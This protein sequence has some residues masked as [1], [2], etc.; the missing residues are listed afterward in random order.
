MRLT[1][2]HGF[3]QPL[4]DSVR[5][6]PYDNEGSYITATGLLNPPLQKK[7][8]AIHDDEIEEDVIDNIWSLLGTTG[9][10][11]LENCSTT[12]ISEKRLFTNIAGKKFSGQFDYL[13]LWDGDLT[14]YKF[15]SVWSVV[16]GHEEWGRQLNILHWLLYVNGYWAERLSICAILRDWDKRKAKQDQNYPQA[17]VVM[18]PYPVWSL[19]EQENYIAERLAMHMA[20]DEDIV[21]VCS[22]EERWKKKDVWAVKKGKNK[23]AV[24]LYDN[25][26]A[27]DNRAVDEGDPHWVEFRP[28]SYPRCDD[29][30]PVRK[31]CPEYSDGS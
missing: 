13:S 2:K 25:Q 20:A 18:V 28:G 11:I 10:K 22:D 30:C 19:E 29:Y 12:G 8:K 7:L 15:T 4:V 3:P 24:R 1:N 23:K 27:A 26:E 14:D 9:H 5:H 21:S 16:Y 31:F 6:R 17:Q